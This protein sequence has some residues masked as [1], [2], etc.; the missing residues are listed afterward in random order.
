[1]QCVYSALADL[2]LRCWP[3]MMSRASFLNVVQSLHVKT[4]FH[5]VCIQCLSANTKHEH[6]PRSFT[7]IL[8]VWTSFSSWIVQRLSTSFLCGT[9]GIMIPVR[10]WTLGWWCCVCMLSGSKNSS[11][12]CCFVFRPRPHGLRALFVPRMTVWTWLRATPATRNL[13][14]QWFH[15]P[16]LKC[17]WFCVPWISL[18]LFCVWVCPSGLSFFSFSFFIVRN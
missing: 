12:L 14:A 13:I 2:W 9:V 6:L 8:L 10:S 1:M 5:F 7:W 15:L 11:G 4:R 16:L 17:L 18:W 3:L